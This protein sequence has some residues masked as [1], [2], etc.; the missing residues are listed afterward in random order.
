MHSGLFIPPRI[1]LFVPASL[2][3]HAKI[4]TGKYSLTYHEHGYRRPIPL[5]CR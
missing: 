5:E 2:T 1:V 4:D 3:T